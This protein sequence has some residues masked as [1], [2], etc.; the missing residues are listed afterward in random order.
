MRNTNP[1]ICL[2]KLKNLTLA[3]FAVLSFGISA[4]NAQS[5]DHSAIP[6]QSG[7]QFNWLAGGGG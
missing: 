4:A 5:L 7:N 2:L 6:Q 3:T 1:S